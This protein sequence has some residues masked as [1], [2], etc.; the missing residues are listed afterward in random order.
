[1]ICIQHRRLNAGWR[2][3]RGYRGGRRL[4]GAVAGVGQEEALSNAENPTF[5]EPLDAE[6][7]HAVAVL[8]PCLMPS[9]LLLEIVSA[10]LAEKPQLIAASWASML[11]AKKMPMPPLAL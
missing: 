11:A 1:M 4:C 10:E 8:R 5:W 9:A 3:L 6:R 7:R 2:R